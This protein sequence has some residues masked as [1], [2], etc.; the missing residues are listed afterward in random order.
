[1]KALRIIFIILC[2]SFVLGNGTFRLWDALID[3]ETIPERS[4]LEAR[5]YQVLPEFNAESLIT[6]DFQSKYEQYVADST[7]KRDNVLLA[8]AS[9]QRTATV[10]AATPFGYSVYPTFFG[11]NRFLDARHQAVFQEPAS[12]KKYPIE[13]IENVC[14]LFRSFLDANES[15]RWVYY[16]PES[17]DLAESSP[18]RQL[19]GEDTVDYVWATT[20]I[21]QQLG[22]KCPV[23]S[24]PY[25]SVETYIEKLFRTDHHFNMQGAVDCYEAVMNA[26]G[27]TPIDLGDYYMPIAQ[28]YIGSNGRNGLIDEVLDDFYDIAYS[29]STIQVDGTQTGQG[30]LGLVDKQFDANVDLSNLSRYALYSEWFHNYN[31]ILHFENNDLESEIGSLLVISDSFDDS[32]DHLF[33]ENY[34]HVYLIDPRSYNASISEFILTHPD[35]VDAA[36][37]LSLYSYGSVAGRANIIW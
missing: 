17:S 28:G 10:L 7:P 34:K 37:T 6:G 32:C 31:Q 11:S 22:G 9:W 5:T 30:G 19:W 16:L 1:M 8:N 27:K 18:V 4:S 12:P 29:P 36:I 24:V 15:I 2:A 33:A 20:L 23:V 25:D 14:E 3:G 26:L 21:S 13:T 35:I